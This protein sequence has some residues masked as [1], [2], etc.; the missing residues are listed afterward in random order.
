MKTQFLRWL[1][2]FIKGMNR[3]KDSVPPRRRGLIAKG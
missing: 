3:L 1:R 2:F